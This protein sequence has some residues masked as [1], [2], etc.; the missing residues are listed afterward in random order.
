VESEGELGFAALPQ[1][2][3]S[4][5]TQPPKPPDPHL[6]RD[7]I[8]RHR[9]DVRNPDGTRARDSISLAIDIEDAYFT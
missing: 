5:A 4:H 3:R 1:L 8:N 9:L 6:L 7:D 2:L